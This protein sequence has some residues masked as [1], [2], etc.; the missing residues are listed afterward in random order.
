MSNKCAVSTILA[1]SIAP[2]L[3]G[4]VCAQDTIKLGMVMPLTGPLATAGQQVLAGARLYIRQHGDTVAGK[5]IE[6]IV[7]DD[8]SSAENGKRLIQ[9][10]IVNDKVDIVGGGRDRKNRLGFADR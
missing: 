8:A 6:L 5:R 7:R 3:V 1:L 4:T 2:T 9:E 10:A